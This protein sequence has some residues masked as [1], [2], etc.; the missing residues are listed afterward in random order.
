[1]PRNPPGQPMQNPRF[2][3]EPAVIPVE[4]RRRLA[5]TPPPVRKPDWEEYVA[6]WQMGLV[7]FLAVFA[8]GYAIGGCMEPER[9]ITRVVSDPMSEPVGAIELNGVFYLIVP[10]PPEVAPDAE[11]APAESPSASL[12]PYPAPPV[13]SPAEVFGRGD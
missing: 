8:T 5:A 11:E 2:K 7:L 9:I 12:H 4:L 13:P 6:V 1:M 10:S 3:P